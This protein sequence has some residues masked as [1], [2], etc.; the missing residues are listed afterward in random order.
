[1]MEPQTAPRASANPPITVQQLEDLAEAFARFNATTE[2]LQSAHAALTERVSQ[3]DAELEEKN[4]QL[5]AANAELRARMAH[6]QALE[7][8][9]R[10]SDRLRALGELAAG[11]AH[12]MRNPLTTIRGFI[13]IL[14]EEYQ[15]EEFRR[16]FSTNVLREIDRLV[17][18]T[19]N[20]LDF[21]RPTSSQRAET[22][23]CEFLEEILGFLSDRFRRSRTTVE[24]TREPGEVCVHVDRG[25]LRQVF[26]NLFSNA[27][28]AME[29]GG[30][31]DLRVYSARR[32]L[33]AER[34]ETAVVVVEVGDQGPGVPPD[35]MS[36]IFDPF[37]STKHH[38]T[39]LGL[40]I[41]HRIVEEH[42]GLLEVENR[43]AGG[44][45]FRVVLPA[46]DRG[47]ARVYP[48]RLPSPTP[49]INPGATNGSGGGA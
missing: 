42:G 12:E 23:V 3:L 19:E 41:S 4:R 30:R 7:E 13:Q 33:A 27:E 20:L 28:E 5:E 10:R 1:M 18:L 14:P 15:Q 48:G 11:V 25:R 6:I 45:L 8:Q 47:S 39:G 21:A 44:A 26:L 43:R 37:V 31:M 22:D 9:A 34:P 46:P 40:A 35:K 2:K 49:G 17:G 29:N 16:E 36:A 32:P 24:W 38:G